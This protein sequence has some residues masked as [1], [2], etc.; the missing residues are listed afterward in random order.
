MG[1]KISFWRGVLVGAAIQYLYDPSAGKHR[2]ARLRE[3]ATALM[4]DFASSIWMKARDRVSLR[5]RELSLVENS[6]ASD[7]RAGVI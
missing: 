5:R 4:G 3:E 6:P 7:I 1:K 2:R